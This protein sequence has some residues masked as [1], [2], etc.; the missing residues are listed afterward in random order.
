MMRRKPYQ[1]PW[2]LSSYPSD[3]LRNSFKKAKLCLVRILVTA[4]KGTF[5][6]LFHF[7]IID[8]MQNTNLGTERFEMGVQG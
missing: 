6:F 1:A 4:P 2:G 7:R 5:F 8:S 3:L